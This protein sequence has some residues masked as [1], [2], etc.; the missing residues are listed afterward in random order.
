MLE[1]EVGSGGS[2]SWLGLGDIPLFC[3]RELFLGTRVGE[4]PG[5]GEIGGPPTT[6]PA[7]PA[8]FGLGLFAAE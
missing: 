4:S 5:A 7:P 8:K 1:E 2:R 6:P 3:A